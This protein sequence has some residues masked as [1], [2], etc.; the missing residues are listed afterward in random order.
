[1]AKIVRNF[2]ELSEVESD[3]Y[4]IVLDPPGHSGWIEPKEETEETKRDWI[5]HHVYL[6]THT[7]YN[8]EHSMK[9]L[10]KYGFDVEF[11]NEANMQ[12]YIGCT[13]D[14][15]AAKM[16]SQ[17]IQNASYTMH[18]QYEHEVV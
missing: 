8:P 3:K 1:M 6:S 12:P 16:A 5:K 2:K 15:S 18:M 10:Q 4:R 7:F 17:K 13:C 9:I 11:A 14:Y